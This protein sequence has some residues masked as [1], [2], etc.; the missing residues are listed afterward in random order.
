MNRIPKSEIIY[1]H[2]KLMVVEDLYIINESININD[3]SMKGTRDSEFSSL[4]KE[5]R[6]EIN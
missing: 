6:T 1:I 4:I 5:R 2:R 3:S